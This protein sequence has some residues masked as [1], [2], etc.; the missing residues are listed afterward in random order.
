MRKALLMI[1]C[2]FTLVLFAC[3]KKTT[4]EFIGDNMNTP[5][6]EISP[7]LQKKKLKKRLKRMKSYAKENPSKKTILLM[8]E[9]RKL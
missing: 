4:Q 3:G 9:R 6:I 2:F 1:I 8:K 7:E 5:F